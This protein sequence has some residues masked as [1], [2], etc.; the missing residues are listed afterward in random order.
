[1]RKRHKGTAHAN[2]ALCK[3]QKGRGEEGQTYRE[4]LKVLSPI[5]CLSEFLSL[6]KQKEA[7]NFKMSEKS[8]A[9]F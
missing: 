1:M 2:S 9:E 7:S 8:K 5:G 6:W 4:F 3:I